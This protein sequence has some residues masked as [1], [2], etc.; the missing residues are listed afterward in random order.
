MNDDNDNDD[1]DDV[2]DDADDDDDDV[3]VDDYENDD[4]YDGVVDAGDVMVMMMM[5]MMLMMI[6][7]MRTIPA[8]L[9]GR[10]PA[11]MLGRP[12]LLYTL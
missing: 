11:E 4:L 9:L 1:D 2:D 3:D 6:M 7:M 8:K 5:M 12:R 10:G